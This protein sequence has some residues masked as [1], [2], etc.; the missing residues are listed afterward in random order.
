MILS[1][2][3]RIEINDISTVTASI[4]APSDR[5]E[6]PRPLHGPAPY[7]IIVP[8]GVARIHPKDMLWKITEPSGT[9]IK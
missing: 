6:L 8:S 2:V 4:P 3:V 5:S 9:V 1:V 7:A